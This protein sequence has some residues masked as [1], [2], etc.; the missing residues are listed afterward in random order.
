MKHFGKSFYKFFHLIN[1]LLIINSTSKRS[2]SA[3]DHINHTFSNWKT[4]FTYHFEWFLIPR[5]KTN[6]RDVRARREKKEK[7][8]LFVVVGY[9]SW[10]RLWK[11]SETI[12]FGPSR[13][14]DSNTFQTFLWISQMRRLKI[15]LFIKSFREKSLEQFLQ[16]KLFSSPANDDISLQLKIFKKDS[17]MDR[18][19]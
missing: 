16:N 6:V 5:F 3:R 7:M 15:I 9:A 17:V 2:G 13:G 12:F 18:N 11:T 19:F 4:L 8:R 1:K 14:A 10:F